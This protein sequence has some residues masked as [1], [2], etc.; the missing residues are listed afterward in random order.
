[1]G[2]YS[3]NKKDVDNDNDNNQSF[4]IKRYHRRYRDNNNTIP[5]NNEK[6]NHMNDFNNMTMAPNLSLYYN[7]YRKK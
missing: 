4:E 6:I 7:K 1:M 2:F 5:T 3:D